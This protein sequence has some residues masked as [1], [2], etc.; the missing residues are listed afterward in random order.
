MS[1]L[2]ITNNATY[3]Y[4]NAPADPGVDSAGNAHP[5]RAL[6]QKQ[7]AGIRTQHGFEVYTDVVHSAAPTKNIGEMSKSFWDAQS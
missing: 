4:E 1:L 2:P 3:L 6:W 5:H 7:T